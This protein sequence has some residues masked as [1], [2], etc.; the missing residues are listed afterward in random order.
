MSPGMNSRWCVK[1]V[2]GVQAD[3]KKLS[4]KPSFFTTQFFLAQWLRYTTGYAKVPPKAARSTGQLINETKIVRLCIS[5]Y[6]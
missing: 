1:V 4:R 6:L 5:L 2:S 3:R